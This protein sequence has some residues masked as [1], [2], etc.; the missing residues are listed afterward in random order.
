MLFTSS[1]ETAK[2]QHQN[3][4]FTTS[5]IKKCLE[6][7]I[8]YSSYLIPSDITKMLCRGKEAMLSPVA[9]KSLLKGYICLY[10]NELRFK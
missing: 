1:E 6:H 2:G 10:V 9:S 8:L 5:E 3:F 4:P 7:K